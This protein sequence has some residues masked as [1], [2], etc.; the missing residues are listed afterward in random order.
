MA[1][2]AFNCSFLP[3]APQLFEPQGA[4]SATTPR[5]EYYRWADD[6]VRR[7]PGIDDADTVDWKRI[8]ADCEKG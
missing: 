2:S 1:A 4:A 8:L 6:W 5:S 7:A 3:K